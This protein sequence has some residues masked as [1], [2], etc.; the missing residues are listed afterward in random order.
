M[1]NKVLCIWA[2][3][4]AQVRRFY[5]LH[6]VQICWTPVNLSNTRLYTLKHCLKANKSKRKTPQKILKVI[7]CC[8]SIERHF[9]LK[10]NPLRSKFFPAKKQKLHICLCAE[11]VWSIGVRGITVTIMLKVNQSL[12]SLRIRSDDQQSAFTSIWNSPANRVF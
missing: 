12:M 1:T 4:K 8:K 10:I 11:V 3:T 2:L 5:T 7:W 6:P 9:F